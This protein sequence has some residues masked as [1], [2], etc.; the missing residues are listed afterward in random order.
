MLFIVR[1]VN[2]RKMGFCGECTVDYQA[3]TAPSKEGPPLGRSAEEPS[4]RAEEGVGVNP[5][6]DGPLMVD[7]EN[8]LLEEEL[9]SEMLDKEFVIPPDDDDAPRRSKRN[10]PRVLVIYSSCFIFSNILVWFKSW[11]RF[12]FPV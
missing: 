7:N 12:I 8:L 9:R 4:Q 1:F 5:Q 3:S 6:E 2:N 10:A 11:L